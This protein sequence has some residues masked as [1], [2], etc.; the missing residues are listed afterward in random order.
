MST[1]VGRNHEC[2]FD[3]SEIGIRESFLKSLQNL[4]TDYV[5]LVTI[6]DVE[7]ANNPTQIKSTV[8]P[9][10]GDYCQLYE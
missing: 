7:F 6:H 2:K 5:D 4:N 10:L 8:V 1:K 3:Y 9:V